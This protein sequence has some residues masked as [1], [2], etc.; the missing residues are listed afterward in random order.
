MLFC[1]DISAQYCY[2]AGSVEEELP[3]GGFSKKHE[4]A[5]SNS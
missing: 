3:V 5:E 2:D 4:L 1:L